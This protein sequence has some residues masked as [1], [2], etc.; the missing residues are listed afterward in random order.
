M[1]AALAL[2]QPPRG[3]AGEGP[4]GT[5]SAPEAEAEVGAEADSACFDIIF[6][7]DITYHPAP[8]RHAT[9]H[10]RAMNSTAMPRAAMPP[11]TAVLCPGR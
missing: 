2:L 3:R 6:G 11:R 1:R 4:A 8:A 9:P 7:S 10:R 5:E